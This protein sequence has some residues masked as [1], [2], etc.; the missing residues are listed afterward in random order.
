MKKMLGVPVVVVLCLVVLG[1]TPVLAAS[2]APDA[3]LSRAVN[4]RS[5]GA[6]VPSLPLASP[7]SCDQDPAACANAITQP[8]T[9]LFQTAV[10]ALLIILSCLGGVGL[11]FVVIRGIVD[12]FAGEPRA[13]SHIIKAMVGILVL[14]VLGFKAPSIAA[15]LVG[16][17]HIS[18]PPIPQA[19][20]G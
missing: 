11:L 12:V 4:I 16:G 10:M 20:S 14:L 9:G 17:L 13:V 7:P 3:H 15:F 8:V 6:V 18:P 1:A 19:T 5:A 2:A